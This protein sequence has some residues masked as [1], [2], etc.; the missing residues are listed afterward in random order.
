MAG[1]AY[2]D[3]KSGLNPKQGVHMEKKQIPDAEQQLT[4]KS[5]EKMKHYALYALAFYFLFC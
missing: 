2:Y 5:N 4:Q 1:Q 3:R